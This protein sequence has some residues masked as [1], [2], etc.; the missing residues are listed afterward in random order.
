MSK[1]KSLAEA[2]I[3]AEARY[4][5]QPTADLCGIWY[6][7]RDRFRSELD[8]HEFIAL[9]DELDG[10]RAAFGRMSV[11]AAEET[12]RAELWRAR[13]TELQRGGTVPEVDDD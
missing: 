3:G 4:H 2:V 5:A 8:A 12:K 1:V 6:A 13:F 11:K 7:A 10:A 9:L